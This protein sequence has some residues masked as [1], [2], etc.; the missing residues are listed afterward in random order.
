MTGSA[1]FLSRDDIKYQPLRGYQDA[2]AQQTGVVNFKLNIDNEA[3]KNNTLIIRRGRP[4]EVAYYAD[5]FSQQDTQT[6]VSTTTI[7]GDAIEEIVVQTG[8]L[9]AE[10]GP[11]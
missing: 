6:G 4:N 9:T 8:G 7:N 3:Q 10:Y 5:A 11:I 1:K 2:V